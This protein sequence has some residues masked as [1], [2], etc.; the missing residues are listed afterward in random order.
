MNYFL[1]SCELKLG[2]AECLSSRLKEDRIKVQ[3]EE[4]AVELVNMGGLRQ[5]AISNRTRAAL[6]I[7]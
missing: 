7:E 4:D 2:N 1:C 6:I 5:A 3:A